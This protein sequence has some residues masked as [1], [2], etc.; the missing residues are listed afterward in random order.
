MK[1]GFLLVISGPSGVGKGTVLH[2]LMNTQKNLVYS[3]SVTTRK[4]RPGEIE[5]VSYFFKSHEEF[6]KMIE[7]DKFLEF[8]KVHDNYYGTPKEFVEEKINEGKI[9]IL[10]IDVQGALNVKKNIDNGVYIFLAP[11]SLSELKNRIVNR[12][13][14]T[15]SDINLRM[16]NAKKELSYIKNYDYLVV[17]DHLNS[18]IN[19]VNEIINAEKHRVFRENINFDKE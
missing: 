3:V 11:P 13:T 16:S 12:G 7:E 18:A 15:E 10:E 6:E 2:D 8:A 5:G 1:K 4:Q 9:V 19:L 14:E 17:N